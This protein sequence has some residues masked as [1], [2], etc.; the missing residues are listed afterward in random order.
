VTE[1][2]SQVS[3]SFAAFSL[4]GAQIALD[5][6]ITIITY[7][8]SDLDSSTADAINRHVCAL[9]TALNRMRTRA[10]DSDRPAILELE[11]AET[12]AWL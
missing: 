2:A 7:Q 8:A 10:A 6:A 11:L 5:R 4:A 9:R 1:T 12:A 3:Q